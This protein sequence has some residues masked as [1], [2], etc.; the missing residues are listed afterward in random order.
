MAE[1]AYKIAGWNPRITGILAGLLSIMGK[2]S[3]AEMLL[4]EMHNSR[5]ALVAPT[6]MVLY[7]LVRSEFDAAADWFEK[8][9]EKRD[10]LLVP[11]IRLPFA[12]ALRASPRWP[13]IA[14]MMNLP[15]TMS[16]LR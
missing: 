13:K 2:E 16:Q 8:A 3:R 11:W 12:K 15:D 9:I 6:G 7:H 14:K 4:E 1:K 5:G 10:P